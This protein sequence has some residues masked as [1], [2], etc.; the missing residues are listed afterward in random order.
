GVSG[1]DEEAMEALSDAKTKAILT[2]N[3]YAFLSAENAYAFG[4][5]RKG[6][7]DEAIGELELVKKGDLQTFVHEAKERDCMTVALGLP[8]FRLLLLEGL[9]NVFEAAN[10]PEKQIE[11]WR[12]LLSISQDLGLLAGEAEAEQK[13]A[14]LES[15]L[16][17]TED[18]V[19]DY[20]LSAGF[21]QSSQNESQLDQVEIDEAV[22]LVQLGREKEALPLV[23]D[24]L[25]YA[26]S[27]DLR[28]LEFRAKL[29]LAEIYQPAGDLDQA[30]KELEEAVRLIIPGP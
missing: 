24:V 14:N 28:S 11:V 26:K 27:H 16:K 30:R 4:L 29:E 18:A 3:A 25:S 1:N 2:G 19:K 5:V 17:K 8:V 10:K 13:I 21:Y 20:A 15:K 9:S 12:E 6:K 7:A 22:L 23:H